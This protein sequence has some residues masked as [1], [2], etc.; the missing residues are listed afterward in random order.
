MQ[1]T[2]R[3]EIVG[4]TSDT[5]YYVVNDGKIC[6][7]SQSQSS[8]PCQLLDGEDAMRQIF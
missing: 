6:I 7:S 4:L 5:M 2:D 3:E 8:R 1:R